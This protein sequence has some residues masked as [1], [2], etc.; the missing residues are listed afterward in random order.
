M[1]TGVPSHVSPPSFG[2]VRALLTGLGIVV[3]LAVLL[4]WVP[5]LVLTRLT[6]IGRSG[7]VAIATAW[8][9]VALGAAAW[10]LRSL[11][12]RRII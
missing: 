3:G 7:R 2:W 9:F 8:F 4:V 12:A 10:A 5:E 6:G 11:Q 1:T